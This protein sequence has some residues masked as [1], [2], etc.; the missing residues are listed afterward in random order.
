MAAPSI[1]A[2][3]IS[4]FSRPTDSFDR[5]PAEGAS[6]PA[7]PGRAGGE[8]RR[9]GRKDS[10]GNGRYQGGD[11]RQLR[12][13]SAPQR[14][15]HGRRLL[16]NLVWPVSHGRPR[17]QLETQWNLAEYAKPAEAKPQATA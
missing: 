15:A 16:G 14:Q 3:R 10:H 4:A 11:R 9:S 1:T 7:C 13:A 5:S 6:P 17:E 2:S 8:S 12:A